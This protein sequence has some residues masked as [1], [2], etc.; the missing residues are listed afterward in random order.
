MVQLGRAR[1]LFFSA[2]PT[3]RVVG[4]TADLLLEGDEA[5][6]IAGDKW[7]EDFTPT[8]ASANATTVLYGTAWTSGTLLARTIQH[9]HQQQTRDRIRRVFQYDAG[10]VAEHV[11]ACGRYVEQQP[12]EPLSGR[13]RF[14]GDL[15]PAEIVE[16]TG[17]LVEQRQVLK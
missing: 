4:A 14:C 17:G 11:C 12:G 9:L 3:A 6:D 13:S 2:E 16:C 10:Q 5:Q 7:Y 8:A 1:A 15:G